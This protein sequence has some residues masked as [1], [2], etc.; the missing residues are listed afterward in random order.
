MQT[1]LKNQD[2]DGTNIKN[3]KILK[4]LCP[5]KYLPELDVQK[6]FDN[7]GKVYLEQGM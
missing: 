5:L 3:D 4:I 1:N 7:A 6:V 2:F